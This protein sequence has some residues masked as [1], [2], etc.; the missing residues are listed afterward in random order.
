MWNCCTSSSHFTSWLDAN[1]LIIKE[2]SGGGGETENL[3][4]PKLVSVM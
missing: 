4:H 1:Y 2:E 3:G